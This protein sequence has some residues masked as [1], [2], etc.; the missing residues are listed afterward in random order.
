MLQHLQVTD[1]ESAH[2]QV[3]ISVSEG[4]NS[5][6]G[7]LPAMLSSH[8]PAVIQYFKNE[9][10]GFTWHNIRNLRAVTALS[11]SQWRKSKVARFGV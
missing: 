10:V 7:F 2:Y 9:V 8:T 1:E 6:F 4:G 3:S 5:C 11:V